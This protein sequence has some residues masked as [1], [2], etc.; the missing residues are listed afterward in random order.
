MAAETLASLLK[1]GTN[2]AT[3]V[4]SPDKMVVRSALDFR[5]AISILVT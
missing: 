5:I 4:T 3:P 1:S 2:V